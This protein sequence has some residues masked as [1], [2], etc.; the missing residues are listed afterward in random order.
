MWLGL[1]EG[2]AEPDLIVRRFRQYMEGS[3]LR[4]SAR[5]YRLNMEPKLT[6]PD[7]LHDTDDLLRPGVVFD[8]AK[9]YELL[10]KE[11]LSLL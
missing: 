8:V 3:G 11:V 5:E 1:T 6:H 9:A 10:D 7:F 4:V 2:K